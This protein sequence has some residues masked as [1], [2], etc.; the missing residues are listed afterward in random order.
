MTNAQIEECLNAIMA[1]LFPQCEQGWND[2]SR[3]ALAGE[4][5]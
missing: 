5:V 4:W 1:V 3:Y 2:W